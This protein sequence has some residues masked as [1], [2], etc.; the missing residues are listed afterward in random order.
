MNPIDSGQSQHDSNHGF[1]PLVF[2]ISREQIESLNVEPVLQVVRSMTLTPKI[3]A[4]N[5]GRLSLTVSG[6][7]KGERGQR[8]NREVLRR[9]FLALDRQFNGWFHVCNRWDNTLRML[10]LAMTPL[11]E[12]Q[13]PG[14]DR[15]RLQFDLSAL[16]LFITIHNFALSRIHHQS[17]IAPHITEHVKQL[18]QAY[19]DNYFVKLRQELDQ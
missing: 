3:T 7:H 4:G 17:G 8:R 15:L 9:Y 19:F 18:M 13:D 6:Y 10:F 2:T 14:S 11:N 16:D 5:A 12:V 1:D